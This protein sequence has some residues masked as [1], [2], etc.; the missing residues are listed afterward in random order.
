MQST[1]IILGSTGSIGTSALR[2]IDNFKGDFKVLGL[3]CNCNISLL[4]EQIKKFSPEFVTV[5]DSSV[6]ASEKYKNLKKENPN[7]E[8]FDGEEGLI[9]LTNK[10]ADIL[11][12]AIVG[13]AGLKPTIN[14]LPN[15]S[16]LALANKET[17]VM[18]GDIVQSH[19]EKNNVELIPVDSEHSAIF[20]LLEKEDKKNIEKLILT[21]SGGSL[22]DRSLIDLKHVTVEEALAHPTWN[23]GNKITIDSS[24]LM[25]KGLEVIEA[26]Y[27]FNQPYE[28]I[29]VI[30]HPESIIH[31]LVET[32]DGAVYAHMGQ[33]DMAFPILN[34]FAY[35]KKR[36]NPFGKINLAEIGNLSFRVY[37]KERFP[38]LKLCYE[39][40]NA[41]G[42]MPAVLN[43]ANEMAV[44]AFLDRAISYIDIVS[45][46][47]DTL[48]SHENISSP[49]LDQI[50][51]AD[52]WA[53]DKAKFYIKR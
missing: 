13:S 5:V 31:S 23:M 25:N 16:R 48:N 19:I 42:T 51:E 39:A 3:S 34:A 33:P 46:I 45:I 30:I 29:E 12:S 24:T 28:S 43:A 8:F 49:N 22:R 38:A 37:D 52:T 14:A 27:L 32:I 53:R 20:S 11:L 35:P 17:L 44:Q 41:K 40:G 47:S 9:E 2:V 21:A 1:V 26:H 4:S 10:K 36:K 6:L 18:A 50:F 7:I 15:I